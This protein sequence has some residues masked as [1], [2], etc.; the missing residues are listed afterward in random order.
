MCVSLC[1]RSWRKWMNLTSRRENYKFIEQYNYKGW[2]LIKS[3]CYDRL[4]TRNQNRHLQAGEI[5]TPVFWS[6]SF[7][8]GFHTEFG[9]MSVYVLSLFRTVPSDGFSLS[10]S[11]R[12]GLPSLVKWISRCDTGDSYYIWYFR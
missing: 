1:S 5:L 12:T 8:M 9:Q 7:D 10:L 11:L 2:H 3:H 4:R 6:P